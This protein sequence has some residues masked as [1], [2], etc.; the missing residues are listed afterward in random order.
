MGKN[1]QLQRQ[2]FTS[3]NPHRGKYLDIYSDIPWHFISNTFW[4]IIRHSI[5]H[6]FWDFI[7][8]V[9]WQ[10][11]W[12]ILVLCLVIDAAFYLKFCLTVHVTF[13]VPFYL[14]YFLTF[15]FAFYVDILSDKLLDSLC[16]FFI[17]TFSRHSI[18]HYMSTF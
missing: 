7:W 16:A 8:H 3:C 4:H 1:K 6:T 12:H 2:Y 5:W 11:I 15:D 13:Y 10:S 18:W 9:V 14:T 17:G